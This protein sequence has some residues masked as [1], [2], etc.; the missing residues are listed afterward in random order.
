MGEYGPCLDAQFYKARMNLYLRNC[1][2]KLHTLLIDHR[3]YR[4]VNGEANESP[5]WDTSVYEY[6]RDGMTCRMVCC[7]FLVAVAACG[8]RDTKQLLSVIPE[9]YHV[10]ILAKSV[11]THSLAVLE[12]SPRYYEILSFDDV[13]TPVLCHDYVPYYRRLEHQEIKELR[14]SVGHESK[15]GKLLFTVDIITRLLDFRMG[16]VVEWIQWTSQGKVT[17]LRQV[18][19]PT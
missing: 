16:D 12:A 2:T 11:T 15:Y 3:R 17:G 4:P 5:G 10:L 19:S 13:L 7:I 18:V 8:K 14:E 1:K 9:N 6:T